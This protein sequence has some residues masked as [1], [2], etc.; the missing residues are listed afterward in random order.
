MGCNFSCLI[1]PA[2]FAPAAL[3]SLL[4][5]S[6]IQNSA[7]FLPFCAPASSSDTFSLWSVFFF[8]S[9]LW[10]FPALLFHFFHLSEYCRNLIWLLNFLR[11]FGAFPLRWCQRR[12]LVWIK[13]RV[14]VA[15]CLVCSCFHVCTTFLFHRIRFM[16]WTCL[17][18]RHTWTN[19]YQPSFD[20]TPAKKL[21]FRGSRLQVHYCR[22]AI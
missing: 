7:T 6:G 18:Q 4:R 19:S 3:A 9:L 16:S 10:L 1:C 2:G 8:L 5:P 22:M 11:Q 20:D 12:E 21:P 15:T 17:F 14:V 13:K